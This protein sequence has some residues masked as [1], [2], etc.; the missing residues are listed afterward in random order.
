MRA[1]NDEHSK[2]NYESTDTYLL[3][4]KHE[5]SVEQRH[6]T[7]VR[8]QWR[9]LTLDPCQS[10]RSDDEAK[11]QPMIRH[12]ELKNHRETVPQTWSVGTRLVEGRLFVCICSQSGQ[13]RKTSLGNLIQLKQRSQFFAKHFH[14]CCHSQY[15]EPIIL[16]HLSY[17]ITTGCGLTEEMYRI[18]IMLFFFHYNIIISTGHNSLASF[19]RWMTTRVR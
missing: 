1:R 7:R 17:Q 9:S 10:H 5:I 13:Y 4:C 16:D 19:D 18:L 6:H 3:S 12:T 15:T 14:I 8:F 11:P 2:V